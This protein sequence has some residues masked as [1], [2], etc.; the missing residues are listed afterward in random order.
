MYH[1]ETASGAWPTKA[2]YKRIGA[3]GDSLYSDLG[4]LDSME[5]P[6]HF[7]MSYPNCTYGKGAQYPDMEWIQTSV[8]SLTSRAVSGFTPIKMT[9]SFIHGKDLTPNGLHAAPSHG[10][11]CL[12]DASPDVPVGG[13]VNSFFFCL[14]QTSAWM[15]GIAGPNLSRGCPVVELHTYTF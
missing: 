11:W 4:K 6:L 3:P 1:H 10:D 9:P 12:I 15:G 8:P 14:V 2:N 7:K 5:K 13:H